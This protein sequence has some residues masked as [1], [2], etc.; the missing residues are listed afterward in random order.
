M[1]KIFAVVLPHWRRI[2]IAA[3]CSFI[4]SGANGSIAW[5]VRPAV[6]GIFIAGDRTY[7][8]MLAMSVLVI[9]ILRGAFT[10]LQNYFMR[11]SGV[12]IARDIRNKLYGHLLYLPMSYY[13]RSSTGAMMSRVLND[14]AVIQELLAYTVR[15]FF[16]QTGTIVA[17][18]TVALYMRWDLT[19]IALVVLPAAF[20]F[21]SRLGKRLKN[22]SKRAQE[23]ISVITEA[24]SEGLSGVKV[25]KSFSMEDAESG[26]F[27]A[28]NQDY[29][30]ELMRSTRIFEASSLIMEFTGGIGIAFVLFYGSS[31]VL[32]KTISA[33]QFFSFIAAILMIYTPAKRLTQVNNALHQASATI[34][35]I[36]DVLAEPR[37]QDG[38]V[39][40][41]DV[42]TVALEDVSFRY[43]GKDE[44]A[45]SGVT[46]RV[47][48]GEVIALVGRSG[49]GKT[50]LVD[51]I[52]GFYK[53]ASGAIYLNGTDLSRVTKKSLRSKIGIVGQD[54]ILF[55]DTVR[56]N[57][58]YGR[59]D[60][61]LED[62]MTASKAAYAHD[63]IMK[64]PLG[65]DTPIG[66]RG[67]R[68]SGGERQR[69]SIARAIFKNPPIL[70]LDEATSALDTESEMI[71]QKALDALMASPRTVFVIAHRLSTIRRAT[72]VVVLEKGTIVESGTHDEL[73]ALGGAYRGLYSLQF[74]IDDKGSSA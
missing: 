19:L 46:L 3:V 68:L 16:V 71:V 21:A 66:Q 36:N 74:G 9:F 38:D 65:Y 32:G 25:I 56:A 7:L 70:I 26:K 48:H 18:V 20:F 35:R 59:P 10:Y 30:R 63:F 72:R 60:A 2:A 54:V 29:Y 13:S 58:A 5:L 61:S 64:L 50:T 47:A 40:A 62:V 14:A 28:S 45:L 4:V 43:E 34:D 69:L 33:G 57:I 15:D 41:G 67:V 1:K 24:L 44:D 31:L 53:P 8:F 11:S 49:A 39:E 51:L 42:Q 37:E 23:K 6:D 73:M 27:A 12:R 55:N 22:V 17:L 52:A